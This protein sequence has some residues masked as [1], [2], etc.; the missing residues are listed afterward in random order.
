MPFAEDQHVIQAIPAQRV[1]R[2]G[3]SA[4]IGVVN[5]L[6]FLSGTW[7]NLGV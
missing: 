4:P 2:R 5:P 6:I 1:I 7:S 3:V